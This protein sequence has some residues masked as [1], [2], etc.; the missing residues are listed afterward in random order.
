[1]P[2]FETTD[3]KPLWYDEESKWYRIVGGPSILWWTNGFVLAEISE[4]KG[5]R[6]EERTYTFDGFL[7]ATES[8]CLPVRVGGCLKEGYCKI[9]YG[10]E[11]PS[12]EVGYIDSRY[13]CLMTGLS[14]FIEPNGKVIIL[15]DKKTG[16]FVRCV[17]CCN[18]SKVEE[19]LYKKPKKAT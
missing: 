16:Q 13:R 3:G 4:V 18:R 14:A 10:S 9:Y 6:I 7:K 2:I 15:K 1:M 17:A 5:V 8:C 19:F 11:D 12:G